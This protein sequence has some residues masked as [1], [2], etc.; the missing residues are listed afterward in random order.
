VLV[1]LVGLDG[2]AAQGGVGRDIVGFPQMSV[3]GGKT[4][5]EET[6]DIDLGT[7]GGQRQ[8]FQ[9]VNVDVTLGMGT[10]VLGV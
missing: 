10:G 8:E 4:A 3:A 5:L 6:D 2:D 7:G 9:I 1:V